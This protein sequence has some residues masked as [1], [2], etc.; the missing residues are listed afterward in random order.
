MPTRAGN[1]VSQEEI[2]TFIEGQKHERKEIT[3][4]GM[5]TFQRYLSSINKGSIEE[6]LDL[7]TADGKVFG[8]FPKN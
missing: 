1:S 8:R 2:E 7:P 4:S 3:A 6:V 5:K